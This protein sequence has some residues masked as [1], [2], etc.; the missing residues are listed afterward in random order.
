MLSCS[1]SPA[2]VTLQ[3]TVMRVSQLRTTTNIAPIYC[4]ARLRFSGCRLN[5]GTD[6][7]ERNCQSP[8]SAVGGLI[9]SR[10]STM[11]ARIRLEDGMS[12]GGLSS[13][14]AHAVRRADHI[15]V[16]DSARVVLVDVDRQWDDARLSSLEAAVKSD[17][18]LVGQWI[19]DSDPPSSGTL[20]DVIAKRRQQLSSIVVTCTG[21]PRVDTRRIAILARALSI[22][23]EPHYT[24]SITHVLVGKTGSAKHATAVD[25]GRPCVT[26]KW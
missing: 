22:T 12:V 2:T 20:A 10:S 23:V 13:D 17:L 24:R 8:S 11:D 5:G 19:L 1:R 6:D 26:V 18:I 25:Q 7:G 9:C 15:R 14:L 16:D 4:T 3:F 21:F